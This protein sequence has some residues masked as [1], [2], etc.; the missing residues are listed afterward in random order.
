[1]E[2]QEIA[3]KMST[4]LAMNQ[5]T[6]QL[7]D[8][9]I[10]KVQDDN[11][12]NQLQRFR[13]DH[14]HHAQEI[15]QWFQSSGQQ[16]SRPPQEF[17]NFMQVHLADAQMARGQDE[18][19]K[20]MH[21]G[22]AADNSEYAEATQA[23]VPQEVKQILQNHLQMEHRHLQAVEQWSPLMSGSGMR[24]QAGTGMG[25]GGGYGGGSGYGGGGML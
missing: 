16:Q 11:V 13:S 9:A 4:L 22:E 20:V 17:Q 12:K 3:T 23:M 21:M 6:V 5:D 14:Q 25:M 10:N 7:Y 24:T 18:V 8:T 15:Q 19:M 2:M 1:M